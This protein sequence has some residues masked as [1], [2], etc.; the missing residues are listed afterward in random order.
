MTKYVNLVNLRL[1]SFISWQLEHAPR[2][3]NKKADALEAVV[4][5]LPIKETML[6]P[7]LVSYINGP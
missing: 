7:V 4:T 6:L 3:S 2:N 1:G 5:S